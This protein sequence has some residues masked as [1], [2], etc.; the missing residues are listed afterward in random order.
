MSEQDNVLSEAEVAAVMATPIPENPLEAFA[1]IANGAK[2]LG[3]DIA[4]KFYPPDDPNGRVLA[5]VLGESDVVRNVQFPE[6]TE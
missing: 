5:M 4:I 3:W 2:L 1:M 6:V